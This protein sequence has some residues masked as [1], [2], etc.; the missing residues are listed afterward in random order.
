MNKALV[1]LFNNLFGIFVLIAVLIG[2]LVAFMFGA[3]F[4]IGGPA[5][6]QIALIGKKFLDYAIKIAAVGVLFGL[7]SFYTRG[8]HE[9]TL[10]N[11]HQESETRE[12]A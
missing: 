2:A 8:I 10:S 4:L 3:G 7:F 1:D 11:D 12:L 6:T 9:L 5:A